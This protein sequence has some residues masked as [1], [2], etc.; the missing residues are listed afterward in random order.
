LLQQGDIM[1]HAALQGQVQQKRSPVVVG[2]GAAAVASAV[3]LVMMMGNPSPAAPDQA[4]SSIKQCQMIQ[5][6]LLVSTTKGSGTVRF[7]ASGYL[8]PPFTLT[9]QPQLVIFPLMRPDTTP[10][11]EIMSVEGSANDVVIT[12]EVTDLHKVFD[13]AGAYTY[14]VTWAPRKSC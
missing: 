10:V 2:I 6:R 14:T 8:S 1:Q 11:E 12:S 4:A 9:S 13:V 3:T 7:R 5:R